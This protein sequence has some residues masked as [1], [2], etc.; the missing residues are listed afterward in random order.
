MAAVLVVAAGCSGGGGSARSGSASTAS[1]T[2]DDDWGYPAL[3][4]RQA[5]LVVGLD[6]AAV[7]KA[8]T[9]GSVAAAGARLGGP[10]SEM[11]AA[12]LK[13]AAV[14]KVPTAADSLTVTRLMVTRAGRWPRWFVAAGTDPVSPTPV[15]R[16][17]VAATAREPY[18]LW[19]QLSLLPGVT[20]AEPADGP[21]GA[22]VV[23]ADADRLVA[24]PAAVAAGYATLLTTGR[25]PIAFA[26]DP[27]RTQVA[28]RTAKDRAALTGSATVTSEHAVVPGSVRG[29]RLTDGSVLVVAAI[30]QTYRVVLRSGAVT[31]DDDLAALAGRATFTTGLERRADE[32]VAFVVPNANSTAVPQLVAAAKA[33]VAV[34]GS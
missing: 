12:R 8:V 7:A 17:Y 20:L 21:L 34:S 13:V 30:R 22:R 3:V 32:V 10:A 2:S 28:A 18:A 25:S 11:L 33:D 4:P 27:L 5:Q 24:S 26:A 31:V 9:G 19:A 16:V 6:Q 29:M 14:R 1:G 15:L 23:A